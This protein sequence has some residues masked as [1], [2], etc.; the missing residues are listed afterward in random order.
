MNVI[1]GFVEF[2]L[3]KKKGNGFGDGNGNGSGKGKDGVFKGQEN[4]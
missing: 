2:A 4:S 1:K 3:A